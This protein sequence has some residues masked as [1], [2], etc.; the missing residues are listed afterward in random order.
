MTGIAVSPLPH[1]LATA[2]L[3]DVLDAPYTGK[4]QSAVVQTVVGE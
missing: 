2:V 3:F 4:D 1:G